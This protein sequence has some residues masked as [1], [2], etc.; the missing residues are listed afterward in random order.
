MTGASPTLI[1]L[2]AFLGI[3]LTFS[4]SL[5]VYSLWRLRQRWRE[6]QEALN[7]LRD[8]ARA[9]SLQMEAKVEAPQSATTN[10]A[11]TAET[12]P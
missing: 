2:A 9:M 10:D 3:G 8:E 6:G 7:S 5:V 4:L 11:K 12:D 1:K